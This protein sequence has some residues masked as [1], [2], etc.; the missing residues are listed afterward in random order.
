[1]GCGKL[2]SC[3][4]PAESILFGM[5]K[6]MEFANMRGDGTVSAKFVLPAFSGNGIQGIGIKNPGYRRRFQ[7]LQHNLIRFRLLTQAGSNADGI[8]STQ[9]RKNSQVIR[10]RIG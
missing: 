4:Y 7:C 3:F 10:V 5:E 6:P 9:R 1:M 2:H 8:H